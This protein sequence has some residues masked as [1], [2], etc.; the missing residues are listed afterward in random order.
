MKY[1]WLELIECHRRECIG[2]YWTGQ[3]FV[4]IGQLDLV[5]ISCQR[6]IY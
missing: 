4:I 6:L 5:E 1:N 3:Q 2:I